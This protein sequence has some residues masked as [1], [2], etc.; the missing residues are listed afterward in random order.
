MYIEYNLSDMNV[1]FIYDFI[2]ISDIMKFVDHFIFKNIL[3]ILKR[4]VLC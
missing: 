3:H 4:K 1:I 2:S